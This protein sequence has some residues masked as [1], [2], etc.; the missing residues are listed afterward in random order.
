MQDSCIA[1]EY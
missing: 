1:R